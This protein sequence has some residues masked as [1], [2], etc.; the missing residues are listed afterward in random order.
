MDMKVWVVLE[1]YNYEGYGDPQGVF[2][3][4]EA[5]ERFAEKIRRGRYP[6]DSVEV[7]EMAVDEEAEIEPPAQP[8]EEK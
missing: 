6:P 3:T 5:A 1:G 8:V 2:S 7:F 4:E